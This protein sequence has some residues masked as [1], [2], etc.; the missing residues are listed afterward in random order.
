MKNIDLSN[1][2][3]TYFIHYIKR[4]NNE[5]SFSWFD[6]TDTQK[7]YANCT[8]SA[9]QTRALNSKK[10]KSIRVVHRDEIKDEC[11]QN[12][13]GIKINWQANAKNKNYAGYV[14]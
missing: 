9:R 14:I 13:L 2:K 1:S 5:S 6:E 3:A 7:Q 12:Y 11:Y 8:H 10:F 4:D